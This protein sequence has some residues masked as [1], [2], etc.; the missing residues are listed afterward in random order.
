[1]VFDA[2]GNLGIGTTNPTALLEVAGDLLVGGPTASN[3]AVYAS[4]G[5]HL[6]LLSGNTGGAALLFQSGTPASPS[7]LMR[8]DGATGNIG[9]G[10]SVVTEK[11]MVAG[12]VVPSADNTHSLGT[13]GLRWT[14]V[15]AVSGSVNTSDRRLKEN[16]QDIAHGL[17]E[18]TALR[19]VSYTQKDSPGR[20]TKL[21][22]IAQEV[23]PV[24]EEVVH[25]GD[26]EDQTLGLYYSD[27]I[28]VLIKAVQEQQQIIEQY[29]GNVSALADQVREL[30]AVVDMLK[31]SIAL[32][33]SGGQE[34]LNGQKLASA[35]QN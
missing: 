16:I 29:E 14:D 10:T 12:N 3:K 27:L 35:S 21:G 18:I 31:D 9:V 25:V 22:L 34:N 7:E 23:L 2:A 30:T 4:S 19:P 5:N 15:F 26:D 8:I 17:D 33:Q 32:Q 24:I 13:S 20:G 6:R 28:P 11:L 1:L